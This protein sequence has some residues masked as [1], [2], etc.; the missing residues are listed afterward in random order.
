MKLTKTE[1]TK[2]ARRV[3]AQ[4]SVGDLRVQIDARQ[5][6][7]TRFANGRPTTGGD[8]DQVTIAVTA[9]QGASTAT[10][11]GNATDDAGLAAL[12]QR[13]EAMAALSPENPEHMP[14]L[15]KTAH[16]KVKA[17][18]PA[19][20]KM[21]AVERDAAVGK[22]LGAAAKAGVEVAGF[23]KHET[24]VV[25]AGDRAGLMAAHESTSVS[26]TTTCR[27][28]AGGSARRGFTS[29]ALA[30][31]D[32]EALAAEAAQWAKR[33]NGPTAMD[34]GRYTVVLAPAAVAELLGFFVGAMGARA[35]AEGRS[36]LSAADGATKVGQQLAAAS[37]DLWSDPAHPAHPASPMTTGGEPH[38]RTEWIRGGRLLALTAS[39]YWADRAGVPAR[40]KP[41]SI[42]LSAGGSGSLEALVGKVG[43]GILVTRF[44]YSRMLERRSLTVTGVTRD[45]T[46]AIENGKI[47]SSVKNFRYNDSPLNMLARIAASGTPVRTQ[48]DRVTVVPPLVIEGF[49]FESVS[50]AV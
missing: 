22:A 20:A 13:A 19:V 30:G 6:G 32:G 23:V 12:V 33:S 40:P 25:V 15:G 3:L 31:L 45:G 41:S 1:M 43:K 39:R 36:A 34:P 11:T 7:N 18:D 27:T 4:A 49:N 2:L 50:D 37:V 24:R 10:A 21:T 48:G 38:A 46:F 9:A 29:H 14:P 47:G 16:D 28:G 5:Q 8:V 42:H 44:W 26:M 17:R 35:A